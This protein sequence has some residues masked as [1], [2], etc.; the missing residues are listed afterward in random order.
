MKD[1]YIFVSALEY[2]EAHLGDKIT[3]EDIAAHSCCSLSALQK[4]WKYCT[5]TGVMTYIKRRRLTLAARELMAGAGVLDTAVKYGYGSNEA[6]T[7]AFRSLWG[8]NP[9]EF[10]KTRS[11]TDI[12]PKMNKHYMDGGIDMRIKFDLTELYDRLTDK[13]DTYIV[14]FDI[15]NLDYIN[16][17]LSREL[18]DEVIKACVRRIDKALGKDMFVFRVGGD[19]FAAVTGYTDIADAER[20]RAE[21]TAGNDEEVSIGGKTAKAY[22]HSGIILYNGSGDLYDEFEKSIVR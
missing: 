2:I 12:Y 7:R 8:V 4:T 11:F 16:K 9:S 22:L 14:C 19:E 6:F 3:Q 20:F 17:Q 5:H 18:G 10:V 21:V 15:K 13:K 1:L